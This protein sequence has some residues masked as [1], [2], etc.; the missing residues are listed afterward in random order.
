MSQFP[1]AWKSAR[2]VTILKGSDRDPTDV[3]S[4][5]PI[6]LLSVLGKVL[7]RV[8]SWRLVKEIA[9]SMSGNQYGFTAGKTCSD[10][11]HDLLDRSANSSEKHT[12]AIF[13]D[14]SGAFDN[15]RWPALFEDLRALGCSRALIELIGS[16][17][18]NR[19]ANYT[20]GNETVTVKLT[21]G[22]PQG[23]VLGPV[24]WNVAMEELLRRTLPEYAHIQAYA[25][26][27]AVLVSASSRV[28]LQSR[29]S[30][31]LSTVRN[32]GD[33]H[34]LTFSSS[35]S[36]AVLTKSSLVPGFSIP[37]GNE[38]I[39][40]QESARYL[41]VIIDQKLNFIPQVKSLRSKNLEIFSRLRGVMGCGW[42]MKREYAL[43]LYR[44]V[45]IPRMTYAAEI[46]AKAASRCLQSKSLAVIQ[47]RALL[48]IT[49][50]YRTAATA[51]LQVIAGVPP[52]DLEIQYQAVVQAERRSVAKDPRR[53]TQGK[54]DMI[55]AWQDRWAN[56]E[57]G[58]WTYRF[59]PQISSRLAKPIW[60]THQIV[61]FLT[62]HGDFR[63]SLHRFGLKPDPMC[64]CGAAE[65]SAEHILFYCLLYDGL[66]RPVE[67]EVRASGSVWPCDPAV[68]VSTRGIY[69][70]FTRFAETA[71][72]LKR[73][74]EV[75]QDS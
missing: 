65:E 59:F 63:A 31:V 52:L 64:P 42:G 25:D 35:K 1:N 43:L 38:R 20:L 2:V 19:T 10:A 26:D 7:E 6:S 69:K 55:D 47:R 58:R 74:G 39:V 24:L 44:A 60:L 68:L 62:G 30:G 12:V 17:L 14:I 4:Y 61:Q 33:K 13:L 53:I 36:T 71:L 23:S 34:G 75:A 48:G 51:A 66:R 49:S 57:Q 22:V 41:G 45:F 21:R 37:F 72:E 54:L 8:I 32:W 5:R 15:I 11:I 46:W 70:A 3:R 28:Q 16:Y 18:S 67:T 29:A 27:I 9:P 73:Q 40:T 56:D 50:A